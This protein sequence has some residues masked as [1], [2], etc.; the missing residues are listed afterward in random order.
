MNAVNEVKKKRGEAEINLIS[1]YVKICFTCNEK[2]P[3][4]LYIL[5]YFWG[6]ESLISELIWHN[7]SSLAVYWHLCNSSIN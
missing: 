6:G 5:S 2:V 3:L 4:W 7:K 1:V